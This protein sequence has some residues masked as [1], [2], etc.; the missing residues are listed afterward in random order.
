MELNFIK[1]CPFLKLRRNSLF[2]GLPGRPPLY[3][4]W[5]LTFVAVENFNILQIKIIP[6]RL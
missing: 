1:I 4:P 6:D 2:M 3:P 5:N